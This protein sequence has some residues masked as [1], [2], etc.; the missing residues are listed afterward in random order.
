MNAIH[1][2]PFKHFLLATLFT[3][4]IISLNAQL[5]ESF[6]LR[7]LSTD[8]K[9]NGITDFRGP[10]AIFDTEQRVDYLRRYADLAKVF[11]QDTA[12]NTQVVSDEEV[13]R[14]LKNIKPQPLPETRKRIL[15]EEWQWLGYRA[16]QHQDSKLA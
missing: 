14:S 1:I 7:H 9:A 12:L 5:S 6:E 3:F 4:V 8:P 15:L 16:G 13:I 10:T 2:S 11:F